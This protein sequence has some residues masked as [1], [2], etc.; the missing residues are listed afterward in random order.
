M[1]SSFSTNRYHSKRTDVCDSCINRRENYLNRHQQIGGA[2]ISAL[3]NSVQT[4]TLE[5]NLGKIYDIF[6]FFKDNENVLVDVLCQQLEQ[7]TGM[8]KMVFD[9]VCHVCQI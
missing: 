7:K 8:K 1:V 2:R 4:E 6:Q 9:F 5:P 3:Q